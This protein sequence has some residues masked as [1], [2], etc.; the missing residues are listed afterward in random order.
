MR[1]IFFLFVTLIIASSAF[2]QM[3]VKNKKEERRQRINALVKQQ[4]EGV[5]TYQK[6]T[7]FGLK[8]TTNGYGVFFEMGRAQSIRR[9]LLYQIEIAELKDPKE[10]KNVDPGFQTAP[11]IYG[12]LNF[13]YPIHL[14]VQEQFLLGNKSNKNGVSVSAN[15]GG[16]ISIGIFRPYKMEV[17]DSSKTDRFV[18]Y[19]SADSALFL[20][21]F[22]PRQV[23]G[24]I[25]GPG[26]GQG[27]N[28][29]SIAPGLYTK[30]AM[31]FD[32]GHFNHT[33]SAIEVGV[34]GEIYAKKIPQMVYEKEKQFFFSGYVSLIFGSRK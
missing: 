33:I 20:N 16:G 10:A 4:E 5:I 2:A 22:D 7:A 31:R 14:G 26:L 15:I 13:F 23:A 34:T 6:H 18:K 8:M 17:I 21:S 12:K 19:N 9:T 29:L 3:T 27:W 11:F 30:A 24:F 28:N 32:Y 1:K 25:G